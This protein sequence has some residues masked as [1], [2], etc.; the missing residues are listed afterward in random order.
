M[1]TINVELYLLHEAGRV[2]ARLEPGRRVKVSQKFTEGLNFF[3]P[4]SATGKPLG[5]TINRK[6]AR[7]AIPDPKGLKKRM[8]SIEKIVSCFTWPT[9]FLMVFGFNE[10]AS[11]E[12]SRSPLD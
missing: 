9:K 1:D 10:E 3:R 4:N 7:N 5:L 6:Q 8:R 2:V 12:R 11:S